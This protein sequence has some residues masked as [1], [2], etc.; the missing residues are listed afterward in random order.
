MRHDKSCNRAGVNWTPKAS[1]VPS[2]L[3]LLELSIL[4]R[5][6]NRLKLFFLGHFPFGLIATSRAL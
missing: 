5:S 2:D 4:N 6:F 3:S 1:E